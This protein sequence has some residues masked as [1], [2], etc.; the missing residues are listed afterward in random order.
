MHHQVEVHHPD[1]QD[2]HPRVDMRRHPHVDTHH[3]PHVDMVSEWS[4]YKIKI[5]KLTVVCLSFFV[6]ININ[7]MFFFLFFL[8]CSNRKESVCNRIYGSNCRLNTIITSL[9]LSTKSCSSNKFI[10]FNV[11]HI[12][13]E[14]L[15]FNT[16]FYS[17]YIIK[18]HFS[19]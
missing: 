1:K 5:K 19:I 17:L 10:F 3:H 7:C 4:S 14:F 13:C 8:N 11:I 6:Q 2:H 18:I 12:F 9:F 15:I 16:H